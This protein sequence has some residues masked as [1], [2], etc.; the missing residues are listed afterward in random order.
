MSYLAL[1]TAFGFVTCA[2]NWRLVS[3]RDN[4]NLPFYATRLRSAYCA[5]SSWR[6]RNEL[7]AAN[8]A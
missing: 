5:A 6:A 8:L 7:V 2:R 4:V 3:M 1:T